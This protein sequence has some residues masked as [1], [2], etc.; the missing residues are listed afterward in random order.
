MR[1]WVRG[2]VRVKAEAEN[3]AEEEEEEEEEEGE[4]VEEIVTEVTIYQT[5]EGKE[6]SEE[7]FALLNS[8]IIISNEEV[9]QPEPKAIDDANDIT[10]PP[11]S[12][13]GC[14][15]HNYVNASDF[16]AWFGKKMESLRDEIEGTQREF[17]SETEEAAVS[18]AATS[19]PTEVLDLIR[20]DV[21]QHLSTQLTSTETEFIPD[22][23]TP[24]P[25]QT[26]CV[27]LFALDE[28]VRKG[29]HAVI[30]GEGKFDFANARNG[31]RV[32]DY[33]SSG[34]P[35]A[36]RTGV[37][38][39]VA[40]E[41]SA[42]FPFF[43]K[44][45]NA[46]LYLFNESSDSFLGS[47]V[48]DLRVKGLNGGAAD[49]SGGIISGEQ[50]TRVIRGGKGVTEPGVPGSLGFHAAGGF[51]L[52]PADSTKKESGNGKREEEEYKNGKRVKKATDSANTLAVRFRAGVYL[53]ELAIQLSRK[54]GGYSGGDTVEYN[55]WAVS[56]KG[57]MGMKAAAEGGQ[58]LPDE[59]VYSKVL[60]KRVLLFSG[61][62][63]FDDAGLWRYRPELERLPAGDDEEGEEDNFDD[64]FFLGDGEEEMKPYSGKNFPVHM[65][66]IEAYKVGGNNTEC[67][68]I[69]RFSAMG[70]EVTSVEEEKDV[71]ARLFT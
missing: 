47:L 29:L 28:I 64:M 49:F 38:L 36:A 14:H 48:R 58:V 8:E 40:R 63:K 5:S 3:S 33:L 44:M 37:S 43:A 7:E 61:V 59:Y 65:I 70:E 34:M 60:R 6:V 57:I 31:G 19:V 12:I 71:L 17:G 66:V 15:H 1:V 41:A 27:S 46:L 39:S 55:I 56:R 11:Q 50:L 13:D 25:N 35:C 16:E 20:A 2:I 21:T 68:S 53:E 22:I 4:V 24:P 32:V 30:Y 54:C 18:V 23:S 42:K 67:I 51:C 62:G 9:S 26:T 52:V 10:D 45:K 69:E